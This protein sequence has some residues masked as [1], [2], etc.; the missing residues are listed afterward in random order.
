VLMCGFSNAS[1]V[2]LARWRVVSV[3]LI[4]QKTDC[5]VFTT[6]SNSY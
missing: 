2:R 1:T 5:N 3:H 6:T 4:V